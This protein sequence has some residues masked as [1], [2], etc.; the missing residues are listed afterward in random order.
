MSPASTSSCGTTSARCCAAR[1]PL[2]RRRRRS[3]APPPASCRPWDHW[4]RWTRPGR[5]QPLADPLATAGNPT[6]IP[7]PLSANRY[8]ASDGQAAGR[9]EQQLPW[10]ADGPDLHRRRAVGRCRSVVC[11]M[12]RRSRRRVPD[13]YPGH[14]TALRRHLSRRRRPR[15]MVNRLA[16][17]QPHRG[18][19]HLRRRRVGRRG[20]GGRRLV[21]LPGAQAARHRPASLAGRAA[22][23]CTG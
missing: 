14:R 12:A 1:R 6:S 8:G 22:A 4:P 9:T 13:R 10:H 19:G 11:A 23:T 15:S 2:A 16:A 17:H 7:S 3:P 21:V 20:R 18:R 5:R